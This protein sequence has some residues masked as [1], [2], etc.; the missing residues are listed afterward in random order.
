MVAQQSQETFFTFYQSI[1]KETYLFVL[2]LL[3]NDEITTKVIEQTLMHCLVQ[4]QK[5]GLYSKRSFFR[6]LVKQCKKQHCFYSSYIVSKSLPISAAQSLEIIT[7]LESYSFFK[8]SYLLLYYV[9]QFQKRD[10]C[11][12]LGVIHYLCAWVVCPITTFSSYH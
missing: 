7:K 6:R 5:K 3:G 2:L 11:F 4:F 10:I 12:I 8:R 1:E 9:A